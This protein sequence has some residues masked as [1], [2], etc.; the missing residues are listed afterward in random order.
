[1]RFIDKGTLFEY[2]VEYDSRSIL[3]ESLHYYPKK[4]KAEVFSRNGSGYSFGSGN[5]SVGQSAISKRVG[6]NST[7][8]SVAAQFNN[9]ICMDINGFLSKILIL[10]GDMG[11][12]LNKT[13]ELI[14]K[15]EKLKKCLIK[16]LGVADFC[17]NDL[18]GRVNKKDVAD[19]KDVIPPQL[20]GL[21][22]A[23]G[24]QRVDE[25]VLNLKHNIA[26]DGVSDEDRMFPFMIES[27]GTIMTLSIMGPIIWALRTGAVIAIDEFGSFLHHEI[28]RWIVNQFKKPGNKHNA[29]LLINTHDQLLMDTEELFR[30]DQICFTE[31][32]RNTGASELYYLSD[33]KNI[34][35]S[36]DPRK[37]YELGRFGAIPFIKVGDLL[38]D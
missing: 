29:Q 21:M 4:Q 34:R 15:D 3:S 19:L 24:N 6:A 12:I 13:I 26:V 36:F 16:A 1:M 27:N 30:R 23:T 2:R 20:M 28:S 8:V 25:I 5:I 17:I 18:E 9:R 10:S 14:G 35:K 7:Y 33:Y 38:D 32:N 37:G 11:G 31:K 22:M